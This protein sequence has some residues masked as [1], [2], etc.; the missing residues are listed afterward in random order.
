M[1]ELLATNKFLFSA[2]G[3]V[4]GSI[5]GEVDGF[6]Y[7]LLVF[8]TGRRE[9]KM[10]TQAKVVESALSK[11]NT[12]VTVATNPYG[13]QCVALIDKIVQ[14]ETGKNMAYTNAIDCLEKAKSN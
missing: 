6:L 5:F 3:G 7:A 13:G 12:K 4:I 10:T 2:L 9:A 11:V 14:E 1:K 8:M